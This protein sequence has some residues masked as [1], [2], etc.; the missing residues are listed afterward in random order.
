MPL[1]PSVRSKPGSGNEPKPPELGASGNSHAPSVL[2]KATRSV[3]VRP[4]A[5]VIDAK[6]ADRQRDRQ[7]YIH[8]RFTLMKKSKAYTN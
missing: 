1:Q 6:H 4:I 3:S 2:K 5:H 8:I 7:T